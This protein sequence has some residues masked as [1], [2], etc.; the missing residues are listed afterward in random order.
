MNIATPPL[1]TFAFMTSWTMAWL[2]AVGICYTVGWRH[3]RR[4]GSDRWQLRHLLFFYSSLITVEIAILSPIDRWANFLFSVH[5]AQHLLLMLAAPPLFWL[6]K[7]MMPMLFGLPT[8]VRRYWLSPILNAPWIRSFLAFVNEPLTACILFIMATWLWH[9]PRL[10]NLTFEYPSLHILEHAS[11][12]GT[13]IL[14]W[15]P[16]IDPLP[17][18]S[19]SSAWWMIPYL[20]LA[21]IQNTLLSAMLTFSSRPLYSHYVEV[22]RVLDITPLDDQMA[23]G[24]LMWVPGSIV[25]L[26]PLAWM[27]IRLLILPE[28]R[29][30]TKR[31]DRSSSAIIPAT[32]S[33]LL[34]ILGQPQ[35]A[36]PKSTHFDLLQLPGLGAFLRWRNARLT[37]Q[38]V[39]LS[40]ALVI[41]GD[42]LFGPQF[43][44]L[45]LAGVLP[46]THGRAFI[47]LGLLFVGNVTCMACPLTLARTLTRG[48]IKPVAVWPRQL[49]SKWLP[50]FLIILFFW[51]YEVLLI[52]DSPWWTAWIMIG[53]FVVA[54]AIDSWFGDATFCKH[55]CPIGQFQFIQSMISPAEIRVKHDSVCQTCRTHDCT[56]GRPGQLGCQLELN[57][58]LKTGN[59]DCTFCLDCV[60]ACPHDNIGWLATSPLP[61]LIDH[62]DTK[63]RGRLRDRFDIALLALFLVMMAFF[64]AASMTEPMLRWRERLMTHLGND[65]VGGTFWF[66]MAGL[67]LPGLLIAL[68]SLMSH[69]VDRGESWRSSV[70]RYSFGLIPL[71][72]A[73]WIA[74]Y[75]FHL[76]TSGGSGWLATSRVL[77][78]LSGM[79]IPI[80]STDYQC[81]IPDTGWLLRFE[82]LSLDIGLLVSLFAIWRTTSQQ[83]SELQSSIWS[84]IPWSLLAILL[85]AVGIWS[86]LQPMEMRGSM[87][88]M[89]G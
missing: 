25:F 41:I 44:P 37:L 47:V 48:W 14:F 29:A 74:H 16:I 60:H 66:V 33:D 13:A 50:L 32:A 40:L 20:L 80:I 8:N 51:A 6:G 59:L 15:R 45:N 46:W 54:F 65:I 18:R 21:D 78:D 5:M 84:F 24:V 76:V 73:M 56:K 72:A 79:T 42:G 58:P 57:P 71:G 49:R 75:V 83:S 19:R 38:I 67:L 87:M 11:F 1:D 7:P 77:S 26:V 55:V 30:V 82:M 39:T 53:Y 17:S 81:H 3:L 63:R 23:A 2:I 22:P 52:W 35:S 61:V 43:A 9:I 62:A 34:P 4:R 89:G 88:A 12:L 36:I 28:H 85:F 10:F 27:T 68:T 64:I 70:T 31:A 69:L 86:V